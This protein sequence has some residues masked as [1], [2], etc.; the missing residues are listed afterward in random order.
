[1]SGQCLSADVPGLRDSVKHEYS[2]MLYPY[3]DIDELARL[4]CLVLADASLRERLSMNAI[5]WARR[6]TWDAAAQQMLE[7]C[8]DVIQ[9]RRQKK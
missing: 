7:L 6:F 5:E 8:A 4:I 2:G 3:G 1:M 9:Q